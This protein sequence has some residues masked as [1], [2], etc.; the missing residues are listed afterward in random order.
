MLRENQVI[1][2]S[3]MNMLKRSD[4][5]LL[6]HALVNIFS[7]TGRIFDFIVPVI[8]DEVETTGLFSF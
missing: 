3:V 1:T 5:D 4:T 2:R 6:A 8:E 7:T